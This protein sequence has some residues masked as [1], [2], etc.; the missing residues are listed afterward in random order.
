MDLRGANLG[1]LKLNGVF[2]ELG[3]GEVCENAVT[4]IRIGEDGSAEVCAAG[5]ALVRTALRFALASAPLRTHLGTSLGCEATLQN[6]IYA[7]L[8]R[9]N[10]SEKDL[11]RVNLRCFDLRSAKLSGADLRSAHLNGT[12]LRDIELNRCKLDGANLCDANLS[13]ADLTRPPQRCDLSGADLS[14]A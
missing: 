12:I 9:A 13:N 4:E 1:L 7:D 8:C 6:L 14:C 11:T 10:L 5:S 2:P 3:A